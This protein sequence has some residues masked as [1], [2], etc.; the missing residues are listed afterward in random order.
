MARKQLARQMHERDS[1][2]SGRGFDSSWTRTVDLNGRVR[3]SGELVRF[4]QLKS[5]KAKG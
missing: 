4:S 1:R 2:S 3:E 5:A